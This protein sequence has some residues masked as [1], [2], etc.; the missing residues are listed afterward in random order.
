MIREIVIVASGGA[1][2]AVARYAIA[3]LS[4][5]WFSTALPWG[6]LIVNVI[7]CFALGALAE[8][9]QIHRL[10][11]QWTLGVG[12]GFLGALTT[13]STFGHETI[14]LWEKGQSLHAV[15]NVA[16]N[17]VAGLIAVAVGI[18]IVRMSLNQA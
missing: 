5:R 15:G 16:M 6:T 14:R 10:T 9:N 3:G 18:Q 4:Y 11:N 8:Y 2:G 1:V 17:L 13:F 12:V 7:G